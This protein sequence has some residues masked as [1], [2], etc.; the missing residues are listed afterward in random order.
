MKVHGFS[1]M[2]PFVGD[3]KNR[4]GCGHMEALYFLLSLSVN[5]KLF[6]KIKS[7]RNNNSI[8]AGISPNLKGLLIALYA[9]FPHCRWMICLQKGLGFLAS[10]F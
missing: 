10:V 3:V 6:L 4:G 2:C 9:Y 7:V 1:Q 5:L 8:Q